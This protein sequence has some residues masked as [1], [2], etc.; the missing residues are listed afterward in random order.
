MERLRRRAPNVIADY[1]QAE[2][3]FRWWVIRICAR[4]VKAVVRGRV[5]VKEA[6]CTEPNS[7][8]KRWTA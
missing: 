3:M 7:N 4:C 8:G 2:L 5:E 1:A 6:L